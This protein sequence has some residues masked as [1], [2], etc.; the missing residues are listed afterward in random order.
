MTRA[1]FQQLALS[2]MKAAAYLFDGGHYDS[3]YYLSGYAVE[4]ALKAAIAR[5]FR[6][7]DLPD[8]QLV[9]ESYVHDLRKLVRSR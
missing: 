1:D 5:Q 3:A 7:H 6:E 8:K 4:C 9:N 2:R